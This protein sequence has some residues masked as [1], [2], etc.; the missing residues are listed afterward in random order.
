MKKFY[1]LN[2]ST[3]AEAVSLLDKY[4]GSAALIAGGTD[5]LGELKDQNLPTQP[6]ALVNIKNISS[7]KYITADSSGLKIGALTRIS[8]IAASSTVTQSYGVLSQAATQVAAHTLRGM[9]TIGGNLCQHVRCWYYRSSG[10][11]FNCIRKGGSTCFATAGDNRYHS[12]FGGPSGCVAVIP[13]DI[14]IALTALGA[15]VTAVGSSG[16]RVIPMASLYTS[17]GTSLKA[18]EV[19]TEVE[20]PAPTAGTT[21]VFMKYRLRAT[22][23]FPVVSVA[24]VATISGGVVSSCKIIL[25]AVSQTPYEATGAEKA[26]VGNAVTTSTASAAAAAAVTGAVPMTNNKYKINITQALVNR[27]ILA[28]AGLPYPS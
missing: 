18:D 28:V 21:G 1:H 17:L 22:L 3:V 8:D 11:F 24:A 5:L 27:A 23:D 26:L 7:L 12:I 15:T 20:V 6:T 9:G 2:P 14:A 13:S 25:G 19:L 16:S 10:N 4:S